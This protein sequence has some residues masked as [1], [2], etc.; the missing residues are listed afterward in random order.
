[1]PLREVRL[2]MARTNNPPASDIHTYG[3]ADAMLNDLLRIFMVTV[4]R[5]EA[6]WIS[7]DD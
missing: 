1:M 2:R 7:P 3:N 6:I 4:G 5:I